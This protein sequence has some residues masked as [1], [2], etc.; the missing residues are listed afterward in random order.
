MSIE[1]NKKH[2]IKIYGEEK[3]EYCGIRIGDTR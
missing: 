2:T 3:W 1:E